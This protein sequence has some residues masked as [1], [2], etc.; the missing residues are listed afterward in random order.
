MRRL[1]GLEQRYPRFKYVQEALF[2]VITTSHGCHV[3]CETANFELGQ[4]GMPFPK[5]DIYA[6]SFL[7]TDNG[8]DLNDL[9]D[10]MNLPEEWGIQNL[11]LDGTTDEQWLEWR[12]EMLCKDEPQRLVATYIPDPKALREVWFKHASTDRKRR[13]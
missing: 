1:E 10:R 11:E 2:F 4:T 5:L 12:F 13:E 3:P 6:Q 9:I 7:A 8:V